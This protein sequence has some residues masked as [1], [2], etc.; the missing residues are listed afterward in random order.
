MSTHKVRNIWCVGR[1][2]KKHA[3]ELGNSV[4]QTPLIFLKAGSCIQAS[5]DQLV[6]PQWM[7]DIHFE[8]EVALQL[9]SDLQPTTAGL[10]IDFTERTIQTQLKK[11]SHPWTLAKSFSGACAVT[12]FVP[13]KQLEDLNQSRFE[14][15]LN[16]Q[17]RQT[18]N[19][20]D[21]IFGFPQLVNYVKQFFPVCPGD[22]IL[23]GTPEGVGAIDNGDSLDV[24]SDFGISHHWSVHRPTMRPK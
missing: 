8:L 14:L 15:S 5:K 1:N 17:I 4:P 3:E 16:G 23:T 7:K 22:L 9:D 11:D 6:F 12:E 20:Q 10:A 18:G 2:Y 24:S 21:M 19:T 13:I